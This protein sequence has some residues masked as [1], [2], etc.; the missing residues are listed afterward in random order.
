MLLSFIL[1][2]Y[3]NI[4]KFF[5]K[6]TFIITGTAVGFNVG[7]YCLL[8]YVLPS[9]NKFATFY[10]FNKIEYSVM[11]R[12]AFIMVKT[13][14]ALVLLA[15]LRHVAKTSL[16][17]LLCKYYRLDP[18]DLESKRSKRVELPTNFLTY[19]LIGLHI[20]FISPFLLFQ[21]F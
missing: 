14:L 21:L 10:T 5:F 6:D 11:A 17:K 2:F 4:F 18:N 13:I 15:L 8:N 9:T 1:F 20:S 12:L 19:F 7:S 3:I 16:N